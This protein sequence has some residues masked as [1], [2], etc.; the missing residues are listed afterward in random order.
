MSSYR[1]TRRADADLEEITSFLTERS[2][3]AANRVLNALRQTFAFLADHP[4]AGSSRD[5]LRSNLRS[6]TARK[7]A[8]RYVVYFRKH[9][10]GVQIAAVLH[11]SRDVEAIFPKS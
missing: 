10:G 2:P 5:D 8:H 1:L 9:R 7:P 11:G 6:F 4:D 3:A